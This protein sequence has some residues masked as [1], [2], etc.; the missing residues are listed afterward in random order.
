MAHADIMESSAQARNVIKLCRFLLLLRLVAGIA[1]KSQGDP[2][3]RAY[4]CAATPREPGIPQDR[5]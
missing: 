4:S 3:P 1:E 2:R 5:R